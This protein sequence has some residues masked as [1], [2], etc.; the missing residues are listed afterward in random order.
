MSRRIWAALLCA[1]VLTFSL[2]ASPTTARADGESNE[3]GACLASDQVWLLVVTDT[4]EVLANQCVG[5][6]A[7]GTEALAEAGLELVRDSSNFICTIGGHPEACPATF[8]GQFW[9]YYQ[10]TPGQEYAFAMVGADENV[11]QAGTIEAWCYNS[12]DE[13]SCTPPYLT[14]VQDGQEVAAPE[15]ITTQD[16]PVTG[17]MI[18][19]PVEPMESLTPEATVESTVIAEPT[20][21]ATD[22]P[23]DEP[24]E[25]T[26]SPVL[27]IAIGVVVVAGAAVAIVVARKNKSGKD[28]A[29][30]GR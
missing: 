16:L 14:I 24:A 5:A 4:D 19:A 13:Q 1:L 12:A 7:N 29:V 20:A 23:T 25:G 17:S 10:G 27:P 22:S 30:G 11:P 8:N 3:V 21:T 2:F 9:N 15:G 28:G 18:D 26:S 6:P